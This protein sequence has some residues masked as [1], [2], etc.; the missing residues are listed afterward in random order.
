MPRNKTPNP[1]GLSSWERKHFGR[2]CPVIGIAGGSGG[3]KTAL[4]KVFA[5]LISIP[6]AVLSQDFYYRDLSSLPAKERAAVN[7]DH[8]AAL[9]V[10]RMAQQI[11]EL[12]A[13]REVG[14]PEYDF[15]QHIQVG[16]QTILP[17]SLLLLDGTLILAIPEI[18]SRIDYAVFLDVPDDVRYRRRIQRDREERDRTPKDI[19]KQYDLTVRPM[20]ERF[21][22]P[23][24]K[25][26][27]CTLDGTQPLPV[28][29]EQLRQAVS[30][31]IGLISAPSSL[32]PLR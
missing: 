19:K 4:I 11:D 31:I 25:T 17:G 27:D 26:A 15:S 16:V 29:A 8:P 23:S 22:A 28:L 3:G 20:Y 10:F 2:I 30:P 9:D 14:A 7:F 21:V 1:S 24:Q 18:R 32:T 5:R 6:V 13:G 12:T